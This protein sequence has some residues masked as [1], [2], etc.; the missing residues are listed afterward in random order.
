MDIEIDFATR[1]IGTIKKID[2]GEYYRIKVNN[3]NLNI[4]DI[5]LNTTDSV[6]LEPLKTPTFSDFN[7]DALS[8]LVGS[9]NEVTSSSIFLNTEIQNYLKSLSYLDYKTTEISKEISIRL[10]KEV[11]TLEY[12]LDK[13]VNL[14]SRI[15]E[16]RFN[17]NKKQLSVFDQTNV[18]SLDFNMD[19]AIK[20]IEL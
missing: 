6:I 12:L 10:N 3:I 13:Q 18:I 2:K 8:S 1:S 11:D 5:S 15:D 7:M 9:L 20:E 16:L 14:S 19:K 17:V 4:W